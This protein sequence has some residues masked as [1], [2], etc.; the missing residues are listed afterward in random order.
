MPR[1]T[2]TYVVAMP[3]STRNLDMRISDRMRPN[4]MASGNA[5]ATM[6]TAMRK[7]ENTAGRLDTNTGG[8]K[9]S[10]RN[11]TSFHDFTQSCCSSELDR[12]SNRVCDFTVIAG[13]PSIATEDPSAS[14]YWPLTCIDPPPSGK[15][16]P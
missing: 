9:N 10:F 1:T 13:M 4:G 14:V 11:F 12:R 2:F 16:T 6:P 15:N 7:P 5:H 8:L 3:R